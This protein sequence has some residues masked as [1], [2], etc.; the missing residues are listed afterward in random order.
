MSL[1]LNFEQERALW[2]WWARREHGLVTDFVA[3]ELAFLDAIAPLMKPWTVANWNMV[4]GCG[5]QRIVVNTNYGS[6]IAPGT[7]LLTQR[8][9]DLLNESEGKR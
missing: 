3:S 8:I 4:L 7:I 6:D 2:A 9:C 5:D 1:T